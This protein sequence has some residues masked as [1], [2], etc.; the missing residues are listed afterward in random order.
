MW[1]GGADGNRTRDFSTTTNSFTIKLQPRIL[2]KS[3]YS[4]PLR[5]SS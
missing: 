4:P 3:T 1:F 5:Y 2:K